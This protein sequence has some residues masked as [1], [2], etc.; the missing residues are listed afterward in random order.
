MKNNTFWQGI[1]VSVVLSFIFLYSTIF[2][3]NTPIQLSHGDTF[4]VTLTLK[5][6]MD[7]ALNNDW[8]NILQMPDFY[9]FKHSLLYSELFIFQALSAFPLFIVFKNIITVFNILSV[10]TMAA[11]SFSMFVFAKYITKKFWPSVLAAVIFVFNPFV[12]GHYPDNLH[13]YSLYFLPLIFLYVEKFLKEHSNKN[14]FLLFLFLALQSLTALTF[15][16]LLTIILPLYTLIRIVQLKSLKNIYDIKKFVNIGAIVGLVLFA[17]V[18]LNINK[19]YSIY[20]KD[21]SF[22]RDLEQTEAFSPWVS[23]LIQVAPNNLVWGWGRQFLKSNFSSIIFDSPE[24]IE[25]DLFFGITVWILIIISFFTLRKSENKKLW[26]TCII[27]SAVCL[28]LSFGPKISFTN[29]FSIPGPYILAWKIDP[30]LQDLRVASRFMFLAYLFI[31]IISAMV[32]AKKSRVFA[33]I[34]IFFVILEYSSVPWKYVPIPN[35]IVNYYSF[36]QNNPNIKVI[37]ELPIGNLFTPISASNNQF[38]DTSYMLYESQLH[39]K[40]MLNGYSSYTPD[41][42][43]PRVEYLSIN[44]PTPS[45]LDQL[46]KWG[47]DAISLHREGF[48]YPEDFDQIESRLNSLGL[49]EIYKSDGLAL[50]KL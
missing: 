50:F 7:I 45:K 35:N 43:I 24:Y 25:R 19:V 34:A 30:L 22:G 46:K 17:A 41:A 29:N 48:V 36:I 2:H 27:V 21:T 32:V 15:G 44:F 3:L 9:G 18:N 14:A 42:Y 47:V 10:L 5:H 49:K 6:Y 1:V 26:L 39:D 13:Y 8:K 11:S 38:I 12:I 40:K 33:L 20:F 4:H 31:A 37:I 16:A 28:L 23:D